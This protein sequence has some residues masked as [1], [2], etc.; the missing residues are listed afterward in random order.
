MFDAHFTVES[1]GMLPGLVR[2]NNIREIYF[3]RNPKIFAFLHEYVKEFEEG[4]DRMFREMEGVRLLEPEYRIVEFMLYVTLRNQKW[5]ENQAL[6]IP[7][8]SSL[9][10][11]LKLISLTRVNY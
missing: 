1:P 2:S 3:S 9:K 6:K 7:L 8:K 11:P 4:V 10:I 5:V